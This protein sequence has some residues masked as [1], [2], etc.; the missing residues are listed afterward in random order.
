VRKLFIVC[1]SGFYIFL[2]YPPFC[3]HVRFF[4][5]IRK[6]TIQFPAKRSGYDC[7]SFLCNKT[8]SDQVVN[9]GA[10]VGDTYG[11]GNYNGSIV[12]YTGVM[13]IDDIVNNIGEYA[14]TECILT[15]VEIPSNVVSIGYY[16]FGC[17][18]NLE[19]I[20][21]PNTITKLWG[22]AFVDC[23]N[24]TKINFSG[25]KEQWNNIDFG[26]DWNSGCSQITVHCTDGDIV[27]PANN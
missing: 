18:Y 12:N 6:D 2:D 16:A 24:L 26:E 3:G 4:D 19:S 5:F 25:T 7:F 22:R 23:E 15:S 13:I 17:C 8:A 10:L 9:D 27:I 11:S 21:L 20:T 14:F 1:L